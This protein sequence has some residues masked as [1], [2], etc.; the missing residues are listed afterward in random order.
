MKTKLV[1]CMPRVPIHELTPDKTIDNA[2]TSPCGR[3]D[4]RKQHKVLGLRS[5]I[6]QFFHKV[7]VNTGIK[8]YGICNGLGGTSCSNGQLMKYVY[9]R[10]FHKRTFLT[11]LA[12]LATFLWCF[13]NY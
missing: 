8:I 9:R 12:I 7:F 2:E 1:Q 11:L 10:G 3:K 5:R 4:E 13:Y 6:T